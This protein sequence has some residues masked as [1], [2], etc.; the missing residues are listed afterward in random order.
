MEETLGALARELGGQWGALAIGLVWLIYKSGVV[1]RLLGVAGTERAQ[2]STD[3]QRLVDNMQRSIERLDRRLTAERTE[4]ERR[5]AAD[6]ADCE[7]RLAE[8]RAECDREIRQLHEAINALT[9]G[10]QR[11]RHLVG[12][13]AQYIASLQAVLRKAGLEVPRFG[14]WDQF[15]AD[16]GDPFL[17]FGQ[18]GE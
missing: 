14:G 7:R 2:L 13:L 3:H 6:R 16:G 4:H 12:N 15:I 17:Q 11:W 5:T 10:E 8:F 18:N 9:R 1:Q